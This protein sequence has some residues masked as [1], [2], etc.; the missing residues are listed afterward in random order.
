KGMRLMAFWII[1]LYSCI[2]W[3]NPSIPASGPVSG[4]IQSAPHAVGLRAPSTHLAHENAMALLDPNEKNINNK[5]GQDCFYTKSNE[6][7]SLQLDYMINKRRFLN[8]DHPAEEKRKLLGGF[9]ADQPKQSGS[10]GG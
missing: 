5:C 8:E 7:I 4:G 1:P 6:A 10:Q 2:A 9:C 3:A